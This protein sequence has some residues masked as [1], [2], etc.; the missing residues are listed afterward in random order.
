MERWLKPLVFVCFL[1]PSAAFAGPG[2]DWLSSQTNPDG[3]NS[4]PSDIATSY[5]STTEA[6]RA[7]QDTGDLPPA[8]ISEA[9][10]FVNNEAFHSTEYLSRKIVVNAAAGSDV[11]ALVTELMDHQNQDGGFGELPG[12]A[13]TV[14][15]TAFALE[16]LTLSGNKSSTAAG[17]AVGYL[18]GKQFPDGSW[19]D[20]GSE[21]SVYT[22]AIALQA[23]TPYRS[24][25]SGTPNVIDA[26]IAYLIGERN[27]ANVW[28]ES[29]LSAQALIAV[30]PNLVDV[31]QI[32]DAIDSFAASQEADGSW[33]GDVYVTALALRATEAIEAA[34]SDPTLGALQGVVVGAQTNLPLA[35]VN[36]TL[37]G[38]MSAS[39]LSDTYGDFQFKQVQ[40]GSYTLELSLAGYETL[41]AAVSVTQGQT[42]ALGTVSLSKGTTPTTG[43]VQ[44][45][46]TRSD[47]G[48]ALPGVT[49]S[50]LETGQS[51]ITSSDGRYQIPNVPA[52]D[53]VLQAA[54]S[55]YSTANA[56]TSITAGGLAVF[57]SS[58]TPVTAPATA[59]E[60]VIKDAA[61]DLPISGATISLS[62]ATT[63][64]ATTD[65]SGA[66]RVEGLTPG[67]LSIEITASGYDAVVAGTTV[68]ENNVIS[69]SPVMYGTGTTPVDGNASGVTGVV[70]DAATDLPISG[71]EIV[72]MFGASTQTVSSDS[73][74]RFSISGLTQYTGELQ[75]SLAGYYSYTIDLALEPLRVLDLGKVRLRQEGISIFLPDLVVGSIDTSG[76][77]SDPRTL[78]LSGSAIANVANTGT[79]TAGAGIEVLFFHD[80]NNNNQYEDGIDEYLGRA[81]T[82]GDIPP[83]GSELIETEINGYLPFRDAPINA[84]VDSAQATLEADES[85]NLGTSILDCDSANAMG[86]PGITV[87]EGY[88]LELIAENVTNQQGPTSLA[89]DSRGNLYFSPGDSG[90]AYKIAYG[91]EL[92]QSFG[93]IGVGD[94]D[95]V[96]VDTQDNVILSGNTVVKFSP[97]GVVLWQKTCPT[98]DIENV[99]TDANDSVYVG[100]LGTQICKISS[101]GTV[102]ET[103]GSFSAPSGLAIGPDG[104]LYVSQAWGGGIVK[105]DPDTGAI[106]DMVAEG[107]F[108]QIAFDQNGDIIAATGDSDVYKISLPEKSIEAFGSG[109]SSAAGVAVGAS[110]EIFISDNAVKTI[111]RA[112]PA[113]SLDVTA[114]AL[115]VTSQPFGLK[116]RVGNASPVSTP[117]QIDVEF[118]EGDPDSGGVLVGRA[119]VGAIPPGEFTDVGLENPIISGDID[120]YAVVDAADKINECNEENNAVGIPG[121]SLY[122]DLAAVRASNDGVTADPQEL[123]VSGYLSVMVENN[124]SVAVPAGVDLTVFYDIDGDGVLDPDADNVLGEAATSSTISAASSD[125]IAIDVSGQLPFR[126]APLA[127]WVDSSGDIAESD[128]ANNIVSTSAAC[129]VDPPPAGALE[130]ELK[131]HWLGSAANPLSKEVY[132]P[133]A[134]GQ[135]TDDNGDGEI[136]SSDIPDLVF[137]SFRKGQHAGTLNAV[138]GADGSELWSRADLGVT[139][140]GSAS[141]ADIDGDGIVEIV[142]TSYRRDWLMALEHDGTLKWKVPAAPRHR[143]APRD[144][145]AIAD[146]DHDGSPELVLGR[147]VYNADGTLRWE[148]NRDYG[149]GVHYGFLP[150]VADVDLTGDMEVLA[151]RTLYDSS[152]NVVWHQSRIYTDGF[153]AVGNFDADDYPEIVVVSAGRVY[154][155][156]HTGD[157]KWGPSLLPGGGAGGA[158]TV[159]DFDGDGA[160]E[161]GVAGGASYAVFETDG[162][163]KWQSPTQDLSSHRT[164]SSVFD[165]EGDGRAEVL[166]ADERRFFVYDGTTGETLVDITNGS[167][168]TLEYPLVV[169]VDNDGAAEVVLTSAASSLVGEVV[170]GVRV[171]ESAAESWAPTRSIW[172][173][174]T[175]HIT[176]INDDGTVPANEQP[177]WLTHNTYRLNTFADRDPLA[178]PDLSASMLKVVDHGAGQPISLTA[179]IGNGGAAPSGGAIKVEF[180]D[181]DPATGGVLLGALDEAAL[182]AGG[183]RDV[184]LDNVDELGASGEIFV[185]VDADDEYIECNEGNNQTSAS[186]GLSVL[187]SIEVATNA[188]D[189]GPDSIVLLNGGITNAG[190]LVGNYRATLQLED[191]SGGIVTVFPQHAVDGV[192]GGGHAT[193]GDAWN[194]GSI[195][196]GTYVLR[197]IVSLP[198]GTILDV[199]TTT[200]TV[201]QG[202]PSSPAATL[203]T[204]TD[205][206]VYHTTAAAQL[207]NLLQNVTSNTLID[208]AL[209]KVTVTDPN[210][211][212]VFTTDID[213]GQ[214]GVGAQRD[215]ATRYSFESAAVGTYS[216][217][218]ELWDSANNLLLATSSAEYQV[219]ND[220]GMALRGQVGASLP[221]LYAGDAQSCSNVISN[222][223]DL[224]LTGLNLRSVLVDMDRQLEVGSQPFSVDLALDESSTNDYEI[225][226][227]E[228]IP[229]RHACILQADID[230]SWQSLASALFEVLPNPNAAPV[231]NAGFDQRASVG[232]S[233]TLDGSAS[234][235]VDGDELSYSWVQIGKPPGSTAV[236]SSV[237]AVMPTFSVDLEGSYAFQLIVSDGKVES[238]ADTVTIVTG[239]VAPVADAGA[240]RRVGVGEAVQLDAS[241]ST[242]AD[243]DSLG[244]QWSIVEAPMGSAATVSDPAAIMPTLDVDLDGDYTLELV[245]NDGELQSEPDRVVLSTYNLAPLADAGL[246]RSINVGDSVIL[247]GSGSYDANGDLLAYHWSL[248]NIPGGST[249][250]LTDETT[251]TPVVAFDQS[252]IYVAQLIVDD[253]QLDSRPDTVVLNV[254]NIRPV[255]DAGPDQTLSAGAPL[256]LDGSGSFDADNDPLAHQ[257]YFTTLPEGASP[258]IEDPTNASASYNAYIA[259]LYVGQLIVDDGV[260]ASEPDAAVI[261][262]IDDVG[263]VARS[264][265]ATPNPV[266]IHTGITLSALLDD[267]KTGGG[268]IRGA[269]YRIDEGSYLPLYAGDGLFDD[270]TENVEA[271]LPAF[272]QTGVYELCVR[273]TDVL[274]NAGADECILL[275]V[276]DPE[277]DFV[278][279]GGWIGSPE[280][281]CQLTYECTSAAGKANFGFVSK[282]KQGA[283]VPAGNSNFVF[284]AGGIHFESDSY[285]WLVVAGAKA[286][287]KGVGTINGAGNFGFMISTTDAELTASTDRDMFRIKIWDRDDAD[288]VVYDNE[289]GA[290]ENDAPTT[291]IGGGSIVIHRQQ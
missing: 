254:A 50:V 209:L 231:A 280:G 14:L 230:G 183:Y 212:R 153:N 154:L 167:G 224:P 210:G 220:L 229:G 161:I 74:G 258:L 175:Y 113:G 138:S 137:P 264:V 126:D 76:T 35:G 132:G 106:L 273:G 40:P 289:I 214:L 281:A 223:G 130:L 93:E 269:E 256:A 28:D 277:G 5:Q 46:F 204:T 19:R 266:D 246:D 52:G 178:Q 232:D 69:F 3:S 172:N 261:T 22:T 199:A 111:Y 11:S 162:S 288:R 17:Y 217:S 133:V 12:Y 202:D 152:G 206:P 200:F 163:L 185:F 63:A 174:H 55:G 278:T 290:D 143:D 276:Y 245:V 195:L 53:V 43:T 68:Y 73:S 156:E 37:A 235:D 241:A 4:L 136:T 54:K 105:A 90:T 239:N 260:L 250:V 234:T 287:F 45:V 285:E 30:L 188:A 36:V 24:I 139:S 181:G 177:S 159:A 131:W 48:A 85:N 184:R 21:S 116:V 84:W 282:Y 249:A 233:I 147:R 86:L 141:L 92:P 87:A 146:I 102:L 243:G 149:G 225:D 187:G 6:L 32:Q 173:Q 115:H 47:T 263:P 213:L 41:T 117:R 179:R 240:D 207:E 72:A 191:L 25:Y 10:G 216:V 255:A 221:E 142:I 62:G 83:G 57:S 104:N 270:M 198:D 27:Q 129:R 226:T 238:D 78:E 203:R 8:G 96:A 190:A 259:G 125:T 81:L 114:S 75:V 99:T 29:Y 108:G 13:S 222:A 33:A 88:G 119:T 7:Y 157:I 44:G 95:G 49:V 97:N 140:R 247:D 91:D 182:A 110:G 205:L 9:L 65:G 194:T 59:I 120:L 67:A 268:D 275:A 60:G 38:P 253:G 42:I 82:N 158:P 244:F 79:S 71:A 124:G 134:V 211:T 98:G 100:S 26:G 56:A 103:I 39:D 189:Y 101:D 236:L 109:F 284:K 66:Y 15:D 128:E 237:N 274:D 248:I 169:D 242:D 64:T 252:G 145:V 51:A 251:A 148:G 135:L 257:W 121:P 127:V 171:F 215:V 279:G 112:F 89:L 228:L 150:S 208:N 165:F 227:R 23:L 123:N 118:Y 20:P 271:S 180:Y 164:G 94:P 166:Y 58:L 1:L 77:V 18:F 265:T 160:P 196:A 193:I 272:G 151:G 70:V 286:Q 144:A 197:G 262:V 2:I 176:N 192:A 186:P 170:H 201:S 283:N 219:E 218:S 31:A 107:S 291:P 61:T 80:R 155:L 267:S 122:P 16:A 168:T 34:A